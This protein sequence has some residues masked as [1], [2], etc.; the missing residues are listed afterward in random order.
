[1]QF[2]IGLIALAVGVG[3]ILKTEWIVQNFGT[4][5]WAENKLGVNGG[6]RLLYKFIGLAII[7]I[8]FLLVTNMFGG[9]LEGTIGR[10]F[11]H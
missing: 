3:V 6:S 7:F 9:F 8:G 2:V 10:I 1:M 11:P 4:N 5:S